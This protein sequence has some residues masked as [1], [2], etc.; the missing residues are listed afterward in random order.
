MKTA[1]S[2]IVVLF[3]LLTAQIASAYYCPST[4]RWLSRDPIGEPGFQALQMASLPSE[5]GN[6]QSSG[7]WINRDP[8]MER[9]GLNRYA[10]IYNNLVNLVDGTGLEQVLIW[11]SAYI[12]EAKFQFIYPDGFDPNA[13][14]SGDGRTGPQI[15]GSSRAFHKLIIETD[16]NKSPVVM[17]TAGGNISTVYYK[18][19][20]GFPKLFFLSAIDAAPPYATVTR[21]KTSIDTIT[22]VQ[23]HAATSDPLISRFI[24]APELHYDY[25]LEFTS[26]FCHCRLVH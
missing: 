7:R 4:G 5:I 13:I 2:I 3:V 19:G 11:V 10:F 8:I 17:N 1:K 21:I 18:L 20:G 14:Y 25:T 23:I 24:Q 12:P 26:C 22:K 15:G 16:P 6:A 9:G